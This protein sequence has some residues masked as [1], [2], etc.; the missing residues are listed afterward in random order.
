MGSEAPNT[1]PMSSRSKRWGLSGPNLNPDYLVLVVTVTAPI[2]HPYVQLVA[3]R[4]ASPNP[5]PEK[6]SCPSRCPAPEAVHHLVHHL[7]CGPLAAVPFFSWV[8]KP[9]DP[10]FLS[11]FSQALSTALESFHRSLL[12]ASYLPGFHSG[13]A[14]LSWTCSLWTRSV[15]DAKLEND[16]SSSLERRSHPNPSRPLS[17][18]TTAVSRHAQLGSVLSKPPSEAPRK[19]CDHMGSPLYVHTGQITV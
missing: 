6:H 10:A 1:G 17:L 4:H 5:S 11:G 15:S 12:V 14:G 18:L 2:P 3:C 16:I 7:A 13:V 9:S 8:S 19:V